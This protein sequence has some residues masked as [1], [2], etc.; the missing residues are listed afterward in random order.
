MDKSLDSTGTAPFQDID[1]S[2][3][4]TQTANG[5][6]IESYTPGSTKYGLQANGSSENTL[7]RLNGVGSG[8]AWGIVEVDT[9][10]V[11][12]GQI[13]STNHDFFLIGYTHATAAPSGKPTIISWT[14]VAP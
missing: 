5:A 4:T 8:H 7:L 10:E 3:D 9:D 1:I 11:L 13:D 2:G 14:E 6:I 12:E